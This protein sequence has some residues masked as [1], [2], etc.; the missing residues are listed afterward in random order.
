MMIVNHS[1]RLLSMLLSV[2]LLLG[3]VSL[4]GAEGAEKVVNIGVTSTLGSLTPC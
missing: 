4:A 2:L 1:K 3:G